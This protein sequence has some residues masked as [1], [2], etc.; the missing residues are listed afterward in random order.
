M[1]NNILKILPWVLGVVML[2][3]LVAKNILPVRES[4]VGLT[5]KAR[6][7][8]CKTKKKT[9]C[10]EPDPSGV[11]FELSLP[12][13]VRADGR[14]TRY[15]HDMYL[16]LLVTSSNISPMPRLAGQEEWNKNY[17]LGK[18]DIR[19]RTWRPEEKFE[20]YLKDKIR[21]SSIGAPDEY[22]KYTDKSA[23]Y[24][25]YDSDKCEF[26]SP[27]DL[28]PS[29]HSRHAECYAKQILYEPKGYGWAYVVCLRKH[30]SPDGKVSTP[31]CQVWS[32][33][34]PGLFM[35]YPINGGYVGDLSWIDYDK[36]IRS[37]ILGLKAE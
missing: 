15:E 24:F 37:Y 30:M 29:R 27:A 1:K 2:V 16:S 17:V 25:V 19:L 14:R 13:G 6:D 12:A 5:Y 8:E 33:V 28:E 22:H 36:R 3:V 23:D 9:R 11:I 21:F 31:V 34:A 35:E 18:S 26:L 20:Y 10:D 7:V 4:T 32:R